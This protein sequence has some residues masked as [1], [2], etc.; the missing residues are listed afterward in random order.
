MTDQPSQPPQRLLTKA[1]RNE[2]YP[3]VPGPSGQTFQVMSL[4]LECSPGLYVGLVVVDE[5]DPAAG[6]QTHQINSGNVEFQATVQFAGGAGWKIG[7]VQTAEPGDF[8]VL[9]K[10]DKRATRHHRTLQGRMKDGDSKGCWYGDEARAN[11]DP[12]A[13]VTV[14]MSD[15][16]NFTFCF[17]RHPGGPGLDDLNG[18]TPTGFGGTKE[19]WAWLVAV[20]EDDQPPEMVFLHHI[21]WHVVYDCQLLRGPG[22]L[23]LK[24]PAT[25]GAFLLGEGTGQGSATP[26]LTGPPP[27]SPHEDNKVEPQ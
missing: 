12:A 24:V 5:D 17:P 2:P 11:A 21:H 14:K 4:A 19:F 22:P 26:V 13:A 25:S 23:E 9:Y 3:V 6:P 10:K 16:P 1:G 8:W 7:W 15:D 18:F 20:R 27:T